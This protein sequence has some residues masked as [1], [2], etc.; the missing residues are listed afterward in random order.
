MSDVQSSYLRAQSQDTMTWF[1]NDP[2]GA[3]KHLLLAWLPSPVY[4][5]STGTSAKSEPYGVSRKI[6]EEGRKLSTYSFLPDR[7]L[8]LDEQVVRSRWPLLLWLAIWA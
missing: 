4:P 6:T 8:L 5:G 3:A 2:T 1:A 7:H